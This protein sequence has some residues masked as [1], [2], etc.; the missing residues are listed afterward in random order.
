MLQDASE[1]LQDV[2]CE[3]DVLMFLTFSVAQR[4]AAM[5][6]RVTVAVCIL[7]LCLVATRSSDNCAQVWYAGIRCRYLYTKNEQTFTFKPRL[8]VLAP[9]LSCKCISFTYHSHILYRFFLPSIPVELSAGVHD[10]IIYF[11]AHKQAD[12]HESSCILREM[13]RVFLNRVS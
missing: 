13:F 11:S 2:F 9:P 5:T 12:T 4:T 10:L 6:R 1:K 8:T 7:V 3:I